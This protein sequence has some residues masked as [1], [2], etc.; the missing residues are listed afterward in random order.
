LPSQPQ[1][2]EAAR[3]GDRQHDRFGTRSRATEIEHSKADGE[4]RRRSG[5]SS[6]RD[7]IVKTRKHSALQLACDDRR[8]RLK[9]VGAFR[10]QVKWASRKNAEVLERRVSSDN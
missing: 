9:R 6:L 8:A 10:I 7:A 5:G 1:T 2:G 4:R 3:N